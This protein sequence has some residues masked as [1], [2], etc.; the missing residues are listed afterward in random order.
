MADLP[1]IDFARLTAEIDEEVRRRRTEGDIPPGFEDELD[2]LFARLSP[3]VPTTGDEFLDALAEAEETSFIDVDASTASNMPGAGPVK[4][5]IRKLVGWYLNYVAGQVSVF[6]GAATRALRIAGERLEDAE[7]RLDDAERR[8]QEERGRALSEMYSVPGRAVAGDAAAPVVAALANASG[9]VLHA[10]ASAGALLEQLVDAG[11]D[12][13]GVEPRETEADEAAIKGLDVRG[14]E[15]GDHLRRLARDTLGGLVLSGCVD[16]L[17]THERIEILDLATT[18]LMPGAPLVVVATK[19]E[20]W[21][22]SQPVLAD[23][24]PGQ[25]LAAATWAHLLDRRGFTDIASSDAGDR[26]VWT[27]RRRGDVDESE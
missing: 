6:A 1:D 7:A 20:R 21:A 17:T 8:R 3:A 25:P 5:G 16:E 26:T 24:A 15:V 13:Y 4:S 12:C 22:A 27:A 9:R 18:R 11:V 23:L 2:E 14:E 19:P 10:D